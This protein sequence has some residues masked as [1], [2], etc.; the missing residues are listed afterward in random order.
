MRIRLILLC[1]C[2]VSTLYCIAQPANNPCSGAIVI[3][4]LNG[5][6]VTGN[7]NTGANEDIG[8]SACTAGSNNNVWFR[9]VAQ[10]PSAEIIVNSGIG[11]PEITVVQFSG[12]PCVA[13]G[14]LEIDCA[15][16]TTLTLDN[17]LVVG[18]T[19]FVMVAFTNNGQGLYDI[20]ID[21]PLPASNDACVTAQLIN[22]LDGTCQNYNNDFPSTDVLTPSCFT[23]STYNVW[24]SFTAVG[25]SLDI[26]IPAGGPG[27]AQMAVIDFTGSNCNTTGAIEL[28]CATGTNH[29]VLDNQLVIGTQYHVVVGFSNSDFDGTGIG[30][31]ELCVDNPIPAPNDPCSGA[32]TIP[33]NVLNNP[34]TCFTSIAGNPLNNDWPST[35]I[36]LFPCWNTGDS[37]NI[38]YS[39]VAQGPDVQITVD[40][41]F[42]ADPQIAL[43][44]YTASPCQLAGAVSL[45]CANGS[46]LDFNDQL[47]IG[48]TYYIAIGFEN[49]AVGNFCM[50]VFNPQPP[51]NDE[52]CNAIPLGTNNN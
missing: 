44:E 11:V 4:Q 13:A 47:V 9:F 23:G 1:I 17:Q 32:I 39:F 41:V 42:N 5:T 2:V 38:W 14:A 7:D 8:P 31:F 20:C 26:N 27:P 12:G 6:C 48:Q 49:N 34:T 40:P 35:D 46:I 21:N 25:V 50:N 52:P 30:N 22:I 51:P 45:D 33:N 19:Y 18:A 16:G 15:A 24:F 10:G 43:V 3:S 28:G 36:G 29:I 37:Y